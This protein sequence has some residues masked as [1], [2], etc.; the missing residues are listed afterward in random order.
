MTVLERRA[1]Q[2]L[3]S[4]SDLGE[5]RWRV[6]SFREWCGLNGFSPATGRRLLKSGRGPTITKLSERRIGITL[7]ANADWQ[8]SRALTESGVLS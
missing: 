7:E 6:L 8:A 3:Q 2:R 4:L 1:E 5:S